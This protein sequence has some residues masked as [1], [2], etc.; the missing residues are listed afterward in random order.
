LYC[1]IRP[2]HTYKALLNNSPLKNKVIHDADFLIYRE[3][4]NGIYF[5]YKGRTKNG[6][7]AYDICNYSVNDITRV[8]NLAIQAAILRKNKLT[9]VDKSNVLE[10][11]KL[12]RETITKMS[13]DYPEL[14]LNCLF[15]DNAAMQIIS[16][17]RSFD[18]LLTENMFGDI[19]SDEASV[20]TGS[21]GLL[22][23][24][25]IGYKNALFEPIHGAYP[26]AVGKNIANPLAC[27]LSM[28]MMLCFW[29]LQNEFI[30][31]K[32]IIEK[33]IIN[34]HGTIDIFPKTTNIGT[35]QIGDLIAKQIL[36][37]NDI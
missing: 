31:I 29:G 5:G 3:L 27:I 14:Q 17:P 30:L 37:Y 20:I 7:N 11:S 9:L 21:I 2:I 36:T 10:T 13:D 23:S 4:I 35:N 22:P 8:G 32:R 19:L 34:K 6:I 33:L 15:V 1:N 25:S 18:V 24:A 28:G 12:W 16:N 26:Q